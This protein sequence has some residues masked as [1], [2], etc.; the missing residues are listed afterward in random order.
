MELGFVGL[1]KMGMNMPTEPS[2][3]ACWPRCAMNSA[4]MPWSR[5]AISGVRVS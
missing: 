1:G 4:V 3:S 5:T 2:R